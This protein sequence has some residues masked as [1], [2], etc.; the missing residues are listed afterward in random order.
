[1]PRPSLFAQVE[2]ETGEQSERIEQPEPDSPFHIA[3]LGDFSGRENR[4]I[5]DAKLQGRKPILIDRDNFE[6]VLGQFAPELDLPL[7]GS[8]GPRVPVR[9]RELDDFH[10]DRI[11]E[12]LKI[13][14]ALRETRVQLHDPAGYEAAAAQVRSWAGVVA[15]QPTPA[16]P[17]VDISR[18][19]ARELFEQTLSATESR[20]AASPA[21]A[22]DDFQAMLRAIVAPYVE[23][24][25]DPQRPELV[26]QVD[27][28]I[29]G[30]M[31]A[32]LHHPDFQ[33]LEAAWR[34]V[35][36]LVRRLAT[37]ANLKIFLLDIAK[38]ELAADMVAT[39]EHLIQHTPRDE[40]W[41]V[42]AGNYTFDPT[43]EDAQL[44]GRIAAVASHAG[45]PFL[46]AASPHV[47]GCNSFAEAPEPRRWHPV[48]ADSWH[49][50]RRLP[51]ATWL[52]LALPRFLLRPP[53]GKETDAT[54]NF[55]FEEFG[56]APHHDHYLWG[57]AGLACAYLLGE[58]FSES[59]W[60]L[61][62]GEV[63][64]IS[65]LPMHVV[66]TDGESYLKPCAEALLSERAAE[67]IL[68]QGL[69]PLVSIKGSDAVRLLRFHSIAEPARALSGRWG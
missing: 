25:P 49:A 51:Q 31:R 42:L 22:M 21:R 38:P 46:A 69:M 48:T 64:E 24:K 35:F 50:L 41:A 34:G 45:A 13:F 5:L 4:D 43:D 12:H 62:P 63:S 61:R 68:D 67:A 59:G 19:S 3:I 16:P 40:P 28:A 17:P 23:P 8:D 7:G 37:G 10:P 2:I 56:P 65:G 6:D 39:Y 15:P 36:L 52:G 26:A 60:D 9:F 1:M 14:Q 11:F 58:A 18:L 20:S 27:A 53:Y 30:Q 66:H 33:A 54:D 47:L 55:A 57:N 32:L 29:S 44:L